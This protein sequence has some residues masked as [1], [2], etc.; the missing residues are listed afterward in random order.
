MIACV[1]TVAERPGDIVIEGEEDKD[2]SNCPPNLEEDACCPIGCVACM[3]DEEDPEPVGLLTV[4][5]E[6][7][8]LVEPCKDYKNDDVCPCVRLGD[9]DCLALTPE[10]IAKDEA[11]HDGEGCAWRDDPD[12]E[13]L[14]SI[15][16]RCTS[17]DC[18][19]WIPF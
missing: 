8:Q 2:S 15:C 12:A 18:Q 10:E 19:Y 17:E 7:G 14:S 1:P 13:P 9:P 6:P 11:E 5:P 16:M 3:T 4:M